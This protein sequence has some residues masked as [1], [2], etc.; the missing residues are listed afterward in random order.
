MSM[1][2]SN[3][4][5]CCLLWRK[6]HLKN[7][8]SKG[9]TWSIFEWEYHSHRVIRNDCLILNGCGW[10][11]KILFILVES[12]VYFWKIWLILWIVCGDEG[13]ANTACAYFF[14]GRDGSWEIRNSTRKKEGTTIEYKFKLFGK[15]KKTGRSWYS[16]K[17]LISIQFSTFSKWFYIL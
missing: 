12:T 6:K 17:P 10:A 5:G 1:L 16:L 11:S 3:G 15:I 9:T 4:D 14:K 8:G 7:L 13:S 2:Y